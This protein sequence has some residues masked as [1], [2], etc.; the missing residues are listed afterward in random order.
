MEAIA[1]CV[2]PLILPAPPAP[3]APPSSTSESRNASDVGGPCEALFELHRPW[4]E[5][6]GASVHHGMPPSFDM[7][8][9]KQVALIEHW[10]RV[11]V[12]NP[13]LNDNYRA[14]AYF[15]IRG[16]VLMSCRRRNY[17]EATHEQLA[18]YDGERTTDGARGWS[19]RKGK[20]VK[21]GGGRVNSVLDTR[22]SA[23]AAMLRR[24][25]QRLLAGSRLY[26]ERL[27]LLMAVSPLPADERDVVRLVLGGVDVT[28]RE[29]R[30]R[31]S[32]AVRRLKRALARD[33]K[34]ES[35]PAPAPSREGLLAALPSL[36]PADAYLLRRVHLEGVPVAALAAIW[37]IQLSN[38]ESR[39]RETL[40]AVR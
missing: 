11:Q 1:L 2:A 15:P 27:R 7:D 26:V 35:K 10:R 33:P 37:G 9:L 19:G 28:D 6:I 14:Y 32:R 4:A 23:E 21:V 38:L 34:P 22:E 5:S 25:E 39:L 13:A 8:D 3:P 18:S 29:A 40:S 31:L 36:P 24:E 30:T 12:Y 20:W 16:A 17:R